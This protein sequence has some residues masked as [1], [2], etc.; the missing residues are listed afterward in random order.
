MLLQGHYAQVLIQDKL[1]STESESIH[2]I[3]KSESYHSIVSK[4]YANVRPVLRMLPELKCTFS[5]I[6]TFGSEP[7]AC[8][9]RF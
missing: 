7:A 6:S 8:L 1:E 9:L 4:I 2:K 3:S 5:L